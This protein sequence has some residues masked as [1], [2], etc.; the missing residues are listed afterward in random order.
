MKKTTAAVI[1]M[2]VLLGGCGSPVPAPPPTATPVQVVSQP[3]P[4]PLPSS[5]PAPSATPTISPANEGCVRA[6]TEIPEGQN[7]TRFTT[8]GPAS[9]C[10]DSVGGFLDDIGLTWGEF[11]P[12]TVITFWT[13]WP[14]D[15]GGQVVYPTPTPTSTPAPTPTPMPPTATP[16][17]QNELLRRKENI[18]PYIDRLVIADYQD[19]YGTNPWTA[20]SHWGGP[21]AGPNLHDASMDRE[22]GLRDIASVYYPMIGAYDSSSSAV[23]DYHVRLAQAMGIDV[24]M[25]DWYGPRDYPGL[26]FQYMDQNFSRLLDVAG[27]HG[28]HLAVLYECKIHVSPW[29][30]TWV[31]HATLQESLDA[32]EDD[33]AY[34]IDR[35]SRHPAYLRVAEIPVIF[36]FA[37]HALAPS[38]WVSIASQLEANGKSFLLVGSEPVLDYYPPFSAFWQWVYPGVDLTTESQYDWI[39]YRDDLLRQSS[40]GHPDSFYAAGVW[41]GFDDTGVWGWGGGPR[42]LDRRDGQTYEDT[43]RAAFDT[44]APW[45]VI[46]TFNDWNEGTIIE[47][48]LE[49]GYEYAIMTQNFVERFKGVSLDDNLMQQITEQYLATYGRR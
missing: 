38:E 33:L 20:W 10:Y 48:S 1:M 17:P 9:G 7:P 2:G 35:Y 43:W 30:E 47:P 23:M 36:V 39:F 24:F 45:I 40:A 46:A 27:Q 42:I 22:T 28:F 4:T 8:S 34:V 41:P 21:D 5:T 16:I 12:G 31:P 25:V 32:I 18:N 14:V 37:P 15:D 3:T 44:Q 19:W 13:E 11:A 29:G 26:G 49:F 6:T